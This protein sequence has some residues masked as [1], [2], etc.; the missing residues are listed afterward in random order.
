MSPA[1]I[2]LRLV[3]LRAENTN[4][5]LSSM[6]FYFCTSSACSFLTMQ[7]SPQV[8]LFRIACSGAISNLISSLYSPTSKPLELKAWEIIISIP[9]EGS[10]KIPLHLVG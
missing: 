1:S 5:S 2:F 3:V 10:F 4:L 8:H 6:L 7:C 9:E